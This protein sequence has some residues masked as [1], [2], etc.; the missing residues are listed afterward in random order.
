MAGSAR[1][2]RTAEKAV[3]K[4]HKLTLF[5]AVLFLVIGLAAGAAAAWGLT[6][7]DRFVLVGDKQIT[8]ALGQAY[9]EQGAEI[10][11]FGRD[12]SDSVQIGGDTVDTGVAGVYQVVYTVED[13]RWGDYQLVRTVTVTETSAPSAEEGV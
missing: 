11:S 9:E 5:L 3:K 4:T 2:R 1:A 6:R 10:V 8:L 13:F 12:I 7:G